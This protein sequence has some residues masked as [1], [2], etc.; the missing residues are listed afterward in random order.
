[1]DKTAA[2]AAAL[3]L[4]HKAQHWGMDLMIVE[5]LTRRCKLG[6]IFEC[7]TRARREREDALPSLIGCGPV[8]VLLPSGRCWSFPSG[9][10]SEEVA[11]L[12]DSDDPEIQR[13]F[14]GDET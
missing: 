9:Y 12:I 2:A 3:A 5:E 14:P 11:R 13:W 7:T 10:D 8:L 4:R 1:M 6:W